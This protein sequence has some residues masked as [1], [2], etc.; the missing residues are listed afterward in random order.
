MFGPERV[1]FETDTPFDTQGGAHFIPAT[2]SGVEG[3]V[4]G[5]DVRAAIFAGKARR[6]LGIGT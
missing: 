2:F 1:L 5:E 6:I 4:P 3:A